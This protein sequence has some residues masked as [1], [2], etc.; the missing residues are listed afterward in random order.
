MNALELGRLIATSDNPPVTVAD[1]LI[2]KG[3]SKRDRRTLI[4]SLQPQVANAPSLN[5][6]GSATIKDSTMTLDALTIFGIFLI[7]LGFARSR[8]NIPGV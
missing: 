8:M 5:R 6:R 4:S 3:V 1:L 7:G 2:Q